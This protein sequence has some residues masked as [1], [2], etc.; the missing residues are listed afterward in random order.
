ME[1]MTSLFAY[2]CPMVQSTEQN[3]RSHWTD[4]AMIMS[5]ISRPLVYV[6]GAN[7]LFDTDGGPA[8]EDCLG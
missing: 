2:F 8:R 4:N 6:E 3:N 1:Q 7:H 5:C